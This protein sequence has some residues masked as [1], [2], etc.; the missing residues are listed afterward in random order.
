M[1]RLILLLVVSTNLLAAGGG[2]YGPSSLVIP[3]VNILIIAAFFMWKIRPSFINYF[4]G[5]HDSVKEISERA[6]TQKFE[7]EMLLEKQKKKNASLSEKIEE[8]KNQ[9]NQEVENFKSDKEKENSLKVSKLAQDFDAKVEIKKQEMVNEINEE[10]LE[11]VIASA[12]DKVKGS[13]ELSKKID[14]SLTQGF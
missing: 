13:P 1:D 2:H 10:L 9:A 5:K 3:I 14:S 7:A 12:K 6:K 11:K 4:S 8:I